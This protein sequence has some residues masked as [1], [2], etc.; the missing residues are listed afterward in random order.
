MPDGSNKLGQPVE[1]I[2]LTGKGQRSAGPNQCDTCSLARSPVWGKMAKN[3]KQCS[4]AKGEVTEEK[5]EKKKDNII[6]LLLN[7]QKTRP[8]LTNSAWVT[9]T[10]RLIHIVIGNTVFC[11]ISTKT[12]FDASILKIRFGRIQCIINIYGK[13]NVAMEIQYQLLLGVI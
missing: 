7:K 9:V 11:L 2:W 12:I 8:M 5:A 4:L 13:Y 6:D 3:L 1:P 10:F